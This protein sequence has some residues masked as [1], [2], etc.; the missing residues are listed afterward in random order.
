MSGNVKKV[1]ILKNEAQ[2]EVRIF[3]LPSQFWVMELN[4]LGPEIE[5]HQNMFYR[6]M[7]ANTFFLT[8]FLTL[9]YFVEKRQDGKKNQQASP[10][11]MGLIFDFGWLR[12]IWSKNAFSINK[13]FFDFGYILI[14][15]WLRWCAPLNKKYHHIFP[16]KETSHFSQ[17]KASHVFRKKK[18]YISFYSC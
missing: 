1:E 18:Y 14:W 17:Q 7:N 6:L 8:H 11:P 4:F 12:D 15:A 13:V 9:E 10:I 3:W 2:N 5:T 16:N